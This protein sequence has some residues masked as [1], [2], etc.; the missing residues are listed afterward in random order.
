[1]ADNRDNKLLALDYIKQQIITCAMPPGSVVAVDEIAAQLG[2]SKT[3]VREALLELQHD[4]Y[5]QVVPRKRTTVSQISL[6]ELRDVYDARSLVE[7]HLLRALT[8]E[9]LHKHR[10]LLLRLREDWGAMD[11][12]SPSRD[13]Y[14]AFLDADVAFHN[15]LIR[16]GGN[17]YLIRFCEELI[18][19]SQRFWYMALFNNRRDV[20]QREHLEILEHLLAGD[21]LAAA[22]CCQK[23]ISISRARSILSE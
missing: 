23:H 3:P 6:Q 11:V 1:M 7:I 9:A 13:A 21:T 14:L 16:L 4:N 15:E 20:V 18:L 10:A 17:G 12:E 5:V 19:K 8:A 2:I 22:E